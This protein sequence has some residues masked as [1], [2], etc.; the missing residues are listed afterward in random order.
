MAPRVD[1]RA[2]LPREAL[3]FLKTKNLRTSRHWLDVWREEH[4]RTFTV[5]QMTE[6]DMVD[7]THRA[8]QRVLRRGETLESFQARMGP[9]LAERGWTPT[10]RGGSIPQRLKRI[11]DTNLRVSASAGQWRRIQQ[12]KKIQPWLVYRLGP[13]DTH[14]VEHEAWAGICLRVDDPWW[15]TH[16]PQNGWGC[17]CYVDQ[18]ARPPK[19]SVTKAPA[20]ETREWVHPITGEVMDVPKGIDPGWD[21][22]PAQHA[23]L[24]PHQGLTERLQRRLAPRTV[25]PS[26]VSHATRLVQAHVEGPSF[27]WFLSQ[28]PGPALPTSTT[29][30]G[31]LPASARHTIK[32]TSPVVVLTDRVARQAAIRAVPIERWA[33]LQDALANAPVTLGRQRWRIDAGDEFAFE[34]RV[35][36]GQAEVVN[37]QDQ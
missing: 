27:E 25:T 21:H 11:Y 37:I 15:S 18:R 8:L 13:S 14:R 19:G 20:Q 30:V 24:G 9:W 3:A 1:P 7:E 23:A 5:A 16:Y 17:Q 34:L 26:A 6:L 32:A 33:A 10:G 2:A 35:R 12:T 4:A 22:N 28:R 29:P 31:L 36:A